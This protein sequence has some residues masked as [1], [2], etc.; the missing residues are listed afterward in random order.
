MNTVF[1]DA[2]HGG[3]NVGCTYGSLVEKHV[4][5]DIA[6]RLEMS[7]RRVQVALPLS[8]TT[9]EHLANDVR[10]VLASDK[11]QADLALI[12]HVNAMPI[13][14][15]HGGLMLHFPRNKAMA[16][17]GIQVADC[18]PR[19]L[20]ATQVRP[21]Y[22]EDYAD[23]HFLLSTYKCDA[24]LIEVGF[25]SNPHDNAFLSTEYGI[26]QIVSSLRQSICWWLGK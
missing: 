26:E 13:E 17:L 24:L 5:L 20:Q 4:T 11:Y 12:I 19:A 10:G 23:A 22:K 18:Y 6:L 8:R 3:H 21:A 7:M 25:A 15:A 9:D 14:R 16:E 1:L 2:G